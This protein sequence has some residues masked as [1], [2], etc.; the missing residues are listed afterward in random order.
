MTGTARTER[1][2]NS[3]N[4]VNKNTTWAP[5]A[6]TLFTSGQVIYG[7]SINY[8]KD[9]VN[10]ALGHYHNYTDYYKIATYGT[11]YGTDAGY[12]SGACVDRGAPFGG[13]G[14][15]NGDGGMGAARASKSRSVNT[16]ILPVALL[17]AVSAGGLIY[18]AAANEGIRA[19]NAL[20]SH[21]HSIDDKT[22][23]V[24]P[25]ALYP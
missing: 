17:G 20:R 10:E 14:Y 6:K 9:R 12:G 3:L 19:V 8:L 18:A 22:A 16:G 24:A 23:P 11:A 2:Q 25:E 4:Y 15:G 21:S 5:Y 13:G 1:A 7:S